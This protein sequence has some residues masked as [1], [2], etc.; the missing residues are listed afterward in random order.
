MKQL[1]FII[2]KDGIFSLNEIKKFVE[3]SDWV[4]FSKYR[5]D[6]IKIDNVYPIDEVSTKTVVTILFD[7]I[8]KLFKK[9]D[10]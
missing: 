6:S 9:F 10:K 2:A 8:E 5:I 1:S 3:K 7:E 4:D